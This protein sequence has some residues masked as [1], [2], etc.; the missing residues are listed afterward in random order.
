[1]V[2]RMLDYREIFIIFEK[3]IDSERDS[4]KVALAYVGP[5]AQFCQQHI[6]I[7]NK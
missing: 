7:G 2:C 3:K 4:N 6:Y 1:M 5:L